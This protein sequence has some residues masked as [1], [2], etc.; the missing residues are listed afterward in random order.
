MRFL[1]KLF[2]YLLLLAII[3]A[4]G[5]FIFNRLEM[6]GRTYNPFVKP[7]RTAIKYS[8]GPVDPQF[9]LTQNQL[10]DTIAQAAQVWDKAA[11]LNLFKYDP[12]APLQIKMVY[13][14]RQQATNEAQSLEAEL[15]ALNAQQT[16]LDKQYSGLN[17][18]YN[19]KLAALKTAITDYEKDLKNYNQDVA[20]WNN[21]GGAPADEYDKLKK[22]QNDLNDRYKKLKSREDD[23]NSLAKQINTIAAQENKIVKNYNSEVT[24]FQNKYGGT[25]EFEKGVFNSSQGI[26]IYQFK[27][28]DDLRMTLIH[29]LGHALGLEHV[30]NPQSIMYYLMGEQ[31]LDDPAPTAEDMAELKNVC[32]LN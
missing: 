21:H 8:I 7:C 20:Y 14:Q 25:Q 18:Q 30:G 12:N 28:T 15:K 26:T 27:E 11:G 16:K 19:Q 3:G 6:Q 2:I 1:R 4:S 24:T 10:E 22:E 29:E 5:V 23:L 9:N 17:T 32:Q 31:N 13:D